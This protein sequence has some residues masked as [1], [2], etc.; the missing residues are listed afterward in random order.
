MRRWL[1]LIVIPILLLLMSSPVYAA[2][3]VGIVVSYTGW[4]GSTV[5]GLT[6]TYIADDEVQLDWVNGPTT[7]M[8]MIRAAVGHTP[9]DR[10][11]GYLVFLGTN[12]TTSFIDDSLDIAG[13]SSVYYEFWTNDVAGTWSASSVSIDTEVLMSISWFFMVVMALAVILAWMSFK[14]RPMVY[15]VNISA[16]F[17]WMGVTFWWWLDPPYASFGLPEVLSYILTA[18]TL[19]M[20][21]GLALDIMNRAN[22]TEITREI[23]GK[24]FTEWGA[25]PKGTVSNYTLYKEQLQGR[26]RPGK[27]RLRY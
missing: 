23:D 20:C 11:D 19:M 3:S 6:I 27:K 21:F 22:Q 14:L 13:P 26:T 1:F 5:S 8:T 12:T 2:T 7:N 15:L 24:R 9:V 18:V 10:D 16:M 17:L 4:V 25:P